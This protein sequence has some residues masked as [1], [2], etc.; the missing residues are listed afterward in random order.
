[1]RAALAE[2]A[3]VGYVGVSM[4]RIAG[5]ARTSKAALYRR[6]PDRAHLIVDAYLRFVVDDVDIP[7]T[8]SLRTD[9]ILLLRQLTDLVGSPVIQ[10]L[11][12]LLADAGDNGEL[13][14]VIREQVTHLKPM[15]MREILERAEARGELRG[16]VT[17]RQATVPI[18]LLRGEILLRDGVVSDATI[19]EI[20]DEV[21]LPLVQA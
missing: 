17:A 20:V 12:G 11:H 3:E 5:R 4:E 21:F 6:W 15:L 18:D 2:L 7:D 1:M 9:V 16:K 14:K 10:M 19:A 13:R 8:G